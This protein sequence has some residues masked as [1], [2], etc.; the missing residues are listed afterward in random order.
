MIYLKKKNPYAFLEA[1]L[2][3]FSL[4]IVY[5]QKLWGNWDSNWFIQPDLIQI[6]TSVHFLCDTVLCTLLHV[7]PLFQ[8]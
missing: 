7:S 6:C 2:S 8:R 3:E 5:F 4:A 1:N